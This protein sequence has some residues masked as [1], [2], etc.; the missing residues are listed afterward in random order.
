MLNF[1]RTWA[2]SLNTNPEYE[3]VISECGCRIVHCTFNE[4]AEKFAAN[5]KARASVSGKSPA[6]PHTTSREHDSRR[7]SREYDSRR[8]Q[9]KDTSRHDSRSGEK[10]RNSD[11]TERVKFDRNSEL[12]GKQ[13]WED[14]DDEAPS[15]CYL[16]GNRHKP[17]CFHYGRRQFFFVWRV[18]GE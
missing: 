8:E 7:E 18:G 11:N 16:C 10:R 17:G 5:D 14:T 13:K 1:T 9:R 6:K 2:H 12:K 4:W 3:Q 15:E